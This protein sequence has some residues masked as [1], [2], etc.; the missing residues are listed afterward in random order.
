MLTITIDLHAKRFSNISSDR[1]TRLA[2][3]EVPSVMFVVRAQIIV[4]TRVL[5]LT[6]VS[7]AKSSTVADLNGRR[8]EY[9]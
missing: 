2:A 4:T 7:P 3:F 9:L 5:G 8:M 1:L 6:C